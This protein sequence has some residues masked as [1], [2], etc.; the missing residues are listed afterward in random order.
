MGYPQLAGNLTQLGL[1]GC[2]VYA[3][4]DTREPDVI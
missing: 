1:D 2:V 4:A 3:A